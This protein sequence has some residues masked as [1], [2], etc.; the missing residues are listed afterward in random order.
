[1]GAARRAPSAE[2]CWA[3]SL[4]RCWASRLASVARAA[5]STRCH[6][7]SG[8]R[9]QARRSSAEHRREDLVEQP[10]RLRVIDRHERLDPAI[11]VAVHQV[12][13]ADQPLRVAAVLEPPDPRVLEELA[14]DRPDPDPLRQA[15]DAGHE[16]ACAADDQVDSTPADEARYSASTQAWS[17]SEFIFRTIPE[18]RPAAAFATSRSTSCR[19]RSR[20]PGR[21]DDQSTERPLARE[22]G[23][24]VEQVARVGADVRPAGEQPEVDVRPRRPSVVVAGPD[25]DVAAQRRRP[26]AARPAASCSASSA[27]RARRR[28]ARR[29]APAGGP[30]RCWPARRTAP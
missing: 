12:A 7:P 1:M 26:R 27:R 21:R 11:E 5:R 17:T 18:D 25:V 4:N 10:A 13:G 28:R 2:R 15:L 22:P 19:N 9:L 3:S 8:A 16:R 20:R 30:T 14:D 24:D 6:R 23:Q 29:P